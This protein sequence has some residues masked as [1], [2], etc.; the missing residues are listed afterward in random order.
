MRAGLF[1]FGAGFIL[2][3]MACLLMWPQPQLGAERPVMPWTAQDTAKAAEVATSV[4]DLVLAG[5]A[6]STSFRVPAAFRATECY[7]E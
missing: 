5:N 1:S 7:T 6:A 2:L 4:T 3:A